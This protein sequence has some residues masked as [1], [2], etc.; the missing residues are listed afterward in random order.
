[1]FGPFHVKLFSTLCPSSL[2]LHCILM[3][4]LL[5]MS[6]YKCSVAIPHGDVGSSAVTFFLSHLRMCGQLLRWYI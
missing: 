6:S 4:A 5:R 2:Q 1:M 3:V